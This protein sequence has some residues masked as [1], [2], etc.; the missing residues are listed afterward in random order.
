MNQQRAAGAAS[1]RGA[2]GRAVVPVS[3]SH[4]AVLAKVATLS[5]ISS[6]VRVRSMSMMLACFPMVVLAGVEPATGRLSR[7]K[8]LLVTL[9]CR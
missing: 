9:L 2:F 7:A 1:D 8:L 4:A 5:A 6:S 3:V